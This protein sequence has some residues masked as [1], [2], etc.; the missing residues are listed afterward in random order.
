MERVRVDTTPVYSNVWLWQKDDD[1]NDIIFLPKDSR[2]CSHS[3]R[4]PIYNDIR[5]FLTLPLNSCSLINE[6]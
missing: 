6:E 4:F 1:N 5:V 2:T 3:V